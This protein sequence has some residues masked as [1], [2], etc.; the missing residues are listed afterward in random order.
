MRA[1]SHGKI[2]LDWPSNY[3]VDALSTIAYGRLVTTICTLLSHHHHLIAVMSH[4]EIAAGKPGPSF[5]KE[6]RQCCLLTLMR[7]RI[8]A[9]LAYIPDKL[10]SHLV[11]T[12]SI[13]IWPITKL[14]TELAKVNWCSGKETVVHPHPECESSHW[15]YQAHYLLGYS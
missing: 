14:L 10:L 1:L 7:E 4:F 13:Q 6:A 5:G 2:L 9:I 11:T 15:I 12:L 3:R 8:S